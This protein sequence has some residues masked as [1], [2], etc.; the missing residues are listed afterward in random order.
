MPDRL[1]VISWILPIVEQTRKS[2]RSEKLVPS[3]LWSHTRWYG[4]MFNNKLRSY[5]VDLLAK[6]GYLAVAPI[7][8]PYFKVYSDQKGMYSNWSE[9]H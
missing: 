5:V 9:R 8:Q 2:N 3:R 6:N 1:S 4:E 7:S